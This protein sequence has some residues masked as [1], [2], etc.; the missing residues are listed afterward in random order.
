MVFE[1]KDDSSTGISI[2][3]CPD[4]ID[5][6]IS[7]ELRDLIAELIDNGKYKLVLDLG[8][9]AYVDSSGLGAIVS[10]I[11]ILR[12]NNGDI[13]L[14]SLNES[15]DS[16]L[17]LTNLNQILQIFDTVKQAMDSFTASE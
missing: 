13:R 11:S 12:T 16:L 3:I 7:F 14:A 6:E 8:K 15:V 17:E 9:T 4:R 2:I 1:I 10:R 5:A